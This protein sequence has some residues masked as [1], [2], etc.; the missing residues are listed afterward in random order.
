MRLRLLLLSGLLMFGC[1]EDPV[2]DD[3]PGPPT[4]FD[5]SRFDDLEAGVLTSYLQLQDAL[6]HDEF[7]A[8]QTAATALVLHAGSDLTGTAQAAADAAD[9][10]ELRNALRLLS[11]AMIETD[12][13]EGIEV[14]YCPMAFNYEGG[15]WLQQSG[16][17]SNPY[18]GASMLRC[19]AFEQEPEPTET[20]E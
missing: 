3:L 13:P 19:G 17:I 4:P 1:G 16:D 10:T 9:I 6:A 7:G 12:L 5:A 11:E 20:E 15:R 8:A 18:Y 14:A 2:P